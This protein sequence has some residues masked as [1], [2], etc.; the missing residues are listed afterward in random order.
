MYETHGFFGAPAEYED[1]TRPQPHHT[2]ASS[3]SLDHQC[4]HV[5]GSESVR[6][7]TPRHQ[8]AARR[9]REPDDR[10]RYEPVVDDDIRPAKASHRADREQIRRT[11]SRADDR[12]QAGCQ[13]NLLPRD[14]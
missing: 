7:W 8:L 12:Y 6:T 10:G 14:S 2:M 13:D 5:A 9:T 11:G 4:D 3:G 1:I